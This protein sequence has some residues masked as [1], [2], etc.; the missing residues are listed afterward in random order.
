MAHTTYSSVLLVF[1]L[2]LRE[3]NNDF[4]NTVGWKMGSTS[5]T[6]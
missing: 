1:N 5:T 2:G 6:V 3:D 4:R